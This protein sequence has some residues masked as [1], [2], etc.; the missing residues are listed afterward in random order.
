MPRKANPTAQDFQYFQDI[1]VQ[2][3]KKT[4]IQ[5][6]L[7]IAQ[8][9]SRGSRANYHSYAEARGLTPA[10]LITAALIDAEH[11]MLVFEGRALFKSIMEA[12]IIIQRAEMQGTWVMELSTH[13]LVD[14]L[15]TACVQVTENG[16]IQK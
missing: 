13:P 11:P 6:R 1:T 3:I 2:A 8:E 9:W 7:S 16:Q 4:T 12:Q 15:W 10:G 5:E 14:G